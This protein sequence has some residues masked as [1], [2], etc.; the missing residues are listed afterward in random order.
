[1]RANAGAA[2][3]RFHEPVGPKN[4][5]RSTRQRRN[6]FFSVAQNFAP[7]YSKALVSSY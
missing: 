1:M 4:S 5:E 2:L 3:E 7:I 6:G